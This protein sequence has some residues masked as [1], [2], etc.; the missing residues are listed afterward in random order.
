MKLNR[1]NDMPVAMEKYSIITATYTNGKVETSVINF[2]QA[3]CDTGYFEYLKCRRDK[4]KSIYRIDV[5]T[6]RKDTRGYPITIVP[7]D[8]S[9]ILWAENPMTEE[10]IP[11]F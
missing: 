9:D 10:E 7:M 8:I 11:L 6:E 3:F 4:V 5:D 2:Y 1:K